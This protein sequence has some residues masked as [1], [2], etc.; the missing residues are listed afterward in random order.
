VPAIVKIVIGG[1]LLIGGVITGFL[2]TRD[3]QPEKAVPINTQ[4]PSSTSLLPKSSIPSRSSATKVIPPTKNT[5]PLT[6][7]KVVLGKKNKATDKIDPVQNHVFKQGDKIALVLQNVSKF[8]K[9][10]DGKNKFDMDMEIIDSNGEIIGAKKELL[11]EEGHVDLP[12]NVAD[13]PYGWI[14]T[15]KIKSGEYTIK[16][17]IYDK[18]GSSR[19]SATRSFKIQSNSQ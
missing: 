4:T 13:S 18:L 17:T 8:N 11:G 10:N 1:I 9:G 14:D 15:T 12:N 3:P 2:M 6:I 19:T 16:L 5:I 7:E